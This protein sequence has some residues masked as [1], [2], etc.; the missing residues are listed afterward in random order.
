L[1][2]DVRSQL[3]EHTARWFSSRSKPC[4][5]QEQRLTSWPAQW[6]SAQRKAKLD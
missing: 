1:F 2:K 5:R 4:T 6:E 3:A